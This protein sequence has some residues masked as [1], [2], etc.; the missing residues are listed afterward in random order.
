MFGSE[1]ISLYSIWWA[2]RGESIWSACLFVSLCICEVALRNF[3]KATS[4]K[5]EEWVK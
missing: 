1:G 3:H 4:Q 2:N 5:L